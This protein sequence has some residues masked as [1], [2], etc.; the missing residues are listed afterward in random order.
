MTVLTLILL[1]SS[2]ALSAD[3]ITYRHA[4][5]KRCQF[6]TWFHREM[7]HQLW[8]EELRSDHRYHP[9]EQLV[10]TPGFL[11]PKPIL[12]PGWEWDNRWSLKLYHPEAKYGIRKQHPN[13]SGQQATYNQCGRL[14]LD[15]ISAG[16]ADKVSYRVSFMGHQ[17]EDVK[18]Y[19]L[20]RRLDWYWGGQTFTDMYLQ[21]RPP[22]RP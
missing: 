22:A 6:L 13:G 15:G 9:P 14:I 18:P 3:S 19:K 17:R 10:F 4:C 8:L 16:T 20:A 5:E 21:V 2:L 12:P 7:T 1:P 11:G